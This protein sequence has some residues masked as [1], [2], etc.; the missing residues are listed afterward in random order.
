[1]QKPGETVDEYYD[2]IVNLYQ[3]VD[4]MNAYPR[5]DKLSNSSM[6]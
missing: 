1:M 6:A 3:R 5:E 2:A 4:P